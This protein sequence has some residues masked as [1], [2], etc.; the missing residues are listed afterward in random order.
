M[1]EHSIIKKIKQ[2]PENTFVIFFI[3]G[4]PYC[5]NALKLLREKNV[6]YKGYNIDEINGT[7]SKLLKILNQNADIINYNKNHTTKP[8]I[9]YNGK[10]IGGFN[11]LNKLLNS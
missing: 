8:I 11:E 10:F 7:M 6:K 1:E 9:F 5:E 3:N 4:C 2:V